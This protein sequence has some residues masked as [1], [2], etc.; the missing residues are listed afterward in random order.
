[1]F[2]L[3]SC[4]ESINSGSNPDNKTTPEV[5]ISTDKNDYDKGEIISIIVKN[6]LVTAVIILNNTQ[7]T[8]TMQNTASNLVKQNHVL[9]V[10][11]IGLTD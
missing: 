11:S 2:F 8:N 9:N 7:R 1:M 5:T 10:M 3:M 4:D 6:G